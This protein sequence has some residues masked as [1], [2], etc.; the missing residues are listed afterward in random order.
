MIERAK[1]LY[2]RTVEFLRRRKR[3]YQLT[4]CNSAGSQVLVDLAKFCRAGETC[5]HPDP[6]MH[7]IAEGR[8]EVWLRIANHLNLSTEQ[9]YSIY[10]G[11]PQ[12][13]QTGDENAVA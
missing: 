6:R 5:F 1:E 8:R 3:A 12:T 2:H 11:N 13:L 7:A 4:F 10:T 9:L